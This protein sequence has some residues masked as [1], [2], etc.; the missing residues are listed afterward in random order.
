MVMLQDTIFL[1][2]KSRENGTILIFRE[3]I[4]LLLQSLHM[5]FSIILLL[6]LYM[7]TNFKVS[8][9]LKFLLN[10]LLLSECIGRT[11]MYNNS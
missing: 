2:Q 7:S 11:L 5:I 6:V 3:F 10:W 4:R 8:R 9:L 1:A